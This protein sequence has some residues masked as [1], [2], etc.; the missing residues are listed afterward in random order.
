MV[1]DRYCGCLFLSLAYNINHSDALLS[2]ISSLVTVTT[3]IIQWL[4]PISTRNGLHS[5]THFIY[6]IIGV[7]RDDGFTISEKRGKSKLNV[8]LGAH[9][10]RA[11]AYVL[12]R[13][14]LWTSIIIV[15]SCPPI[16]YST[17]DIIMRAEYVFSAVLYF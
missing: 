1:L 11:H 15:Q 6:T 14:I 8:V 5:I 4:V 10:D 9:I 2:D 7:N 12:M 16:T 3:S 13:W 17:T